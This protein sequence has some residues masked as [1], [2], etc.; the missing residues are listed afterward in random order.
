MS[1]RKTLQRS[2]GALGG[3]QKNWIYTDAKLASINGGY[4]NIATGDYTTLGGGVKNKAYSNYATVLGGYLGKCNSKFATIGGG[5]RNT[6]AGR[7][8]LALGTRVKVTGDYSM[9]LG[10]AGTSNC[11]VRG[12]NS[13]GIC[14]DSVVISG[15]N[16]E[17]DLVTVLEDGRQLSEATKTVEDLEEEKE[18]LEEELRTKIEALLA[19]GGV[20]AGAVDFI[21]SM[22][23]SL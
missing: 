8:G 10:F 6:V 7:F 5:S 14:A 15:T 12:D 17:L 3:G 9:G 16:G 19:K 18:E 2:Y 4:H 11:Y 1:A 22:L 21:E 23:S 20:R 13:F